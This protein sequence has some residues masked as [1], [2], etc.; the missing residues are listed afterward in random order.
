L[1]ESERSL[2]LV[3]DNVPALISYIDRNHRYRFVNARYR[4]WRGVDHESAVGVHMSDML[5]PELY[6]QRLPY[7]ERVL[8]GEAVRFESITPHRE[9]G[10]RTTDVGYVPHVGRNGVVQGFYV[11]GFDITERKRTEEV[12]RIRARQQHAVAELGKLALRE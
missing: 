10:H 1:A 12:L 6:E 9:L 7:I 8:K 11:L 3:S 5:G 2:R 4:E